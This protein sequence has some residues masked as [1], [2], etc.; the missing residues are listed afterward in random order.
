MPGFMVMETIRWSK[1]REGI[2]SSKYSLDFAT[3]TEHLYLKDKY[4]TNHQNNWHN[5]DP[6]YRKVEKNHLPPEVMGSCQA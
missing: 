4:D 6:C 2:L 1:K 5:G 3:S